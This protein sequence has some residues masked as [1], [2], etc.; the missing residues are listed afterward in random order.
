MLY[1][2]MKFFGEGTGYNNVAE[3]LKGSYSDGYLGNLGYSNVQ[4]AQIPSNVQRLSLSCPYGTIGKFLDFGVNPLAENRNTCVTNAKNSAC[5][6]DASFIADAFATSIG[7]DS[8]LFSYENKSLY[9]DDGDHSACSSDSSTLFV[10]FTC[11][12]DAASQ[13]AKYEQMSLAVATGVLICL[14]FTVTI[15][16]LY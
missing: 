16:A 15:R 11:I 6:P 4:C 12:Q 1:P 2:T 14:L 5:K 10:Q 3:V 7:L 9:A 13:S 8:F